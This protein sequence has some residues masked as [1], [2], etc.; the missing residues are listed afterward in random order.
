MVPHEFH[1]RSP[2]FQALLADRRTRVVNVA[3]RPA[4]AIHE[5]ASASLV[6]SSSLHGLIVADSYG[7]P[8]AWV[9]TDVEL[10]GGDFKFRDYHSVVLPDE[11]RHIVLNERTKLEDLATTARKADPDRVQ[12]AGDQLERALLRFIKGERPS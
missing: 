9:T 6:V 12:A 1:V 4:H 11:N 10:W 7:I 8:A 5:I 3:R 2:A